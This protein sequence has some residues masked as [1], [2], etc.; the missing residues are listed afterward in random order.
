MASFVYDAALRGMAT[1][2]LDLTTTATPTLSALLVDSQYTASQTADVYVSSITTA[3]R[4][5]TL[6]ALSSVTVAAPFTVDFADPQYSALTG[7][8]VAGVVVFADTGAD[9]TS[10]LVSYHVV[11]PAYVPNGADI[12][13]SIPTTGAIYKA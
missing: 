1:G 3:A 5:A 2:D 6:G 8:T 7:A 10:R 11:T 13:V 12:V 4:L 9:A